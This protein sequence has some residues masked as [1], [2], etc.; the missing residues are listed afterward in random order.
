ML[1]PWGL[2]GLL[3]VLV[4]WPFGTALDWVLVQIVT[5]VAFGWSFSLQ[6]NWTH[7]PAL[8]LMRFGCLL[9]AVVLP[10]IRLLRASPALM[11]RE[12]AT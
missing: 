9:L 8:L 1:L 6:P 3:C 2:L 11:L 7:Y 4:V 5:P 10:G 12:E